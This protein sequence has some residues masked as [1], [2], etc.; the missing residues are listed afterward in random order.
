MAKQNFVVLYAQSCR[1]TGDWRLIVYFMLQILLLSAP[2]YIFTRPFRQHLLPGRTDNPEILGLFLLGWSLLYALLSV[3]GMC[4]S[5]GEKTRIFGDFKAGLARWKSA[6]H[7][8]PWILLPT[9]LCN[10]LL[11]AVPGGVIPFVLLTVLLVLSTVLP[12][13]LLSFLCAAIAAAPPERGIVKIYRDAFRAI[14]NGWG[15]WLIALLNTLAGF[16][17]G[18]LVAAFL[19]SILE[20]A[21]VNFDVINSL[22]LWLISAWCSAFICSFIVRLYAEAVPEVET[23]GKDGNI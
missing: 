2:I 5:A 19:S 23:P 20:I 15:R 6:P 14:R 3:V 9:I 10:T 22:L 7:L 21:G 17:A 1:R 12:W 8:L 13:C 4:G 16:F 11:H 18:V